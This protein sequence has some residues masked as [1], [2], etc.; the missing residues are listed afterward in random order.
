MYLLP[1]SFYSNLFFL[2]WFV[3]LF[4]N[5][6]VSFKESR[7]LLRVFG[8]VFIVVGGIARIIAENSLEEI[9]TAFC[10]IYAGMVL[11]F[12]AY[13]AFKVLSDEEEKT[14]LEESE[15]EPAQ[16]DEIQ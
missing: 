8:L 15:R 6:W 2:I 11:L 3:Y 13:C 1:E 7:L 4:F 10:F 5:I 16:S 9:T 12:T 14:L